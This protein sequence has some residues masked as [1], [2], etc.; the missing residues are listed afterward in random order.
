MDRELPSSDRRPLA[1]AVRQFGR[2]SG[3][4][5]G[6]IVAGALLVG[7]DDGGETPSTRFTE[8]PEVSLGQAIEGELSS[9]SDVNLKDGSRQGS[10]WVCANKDADSS[11]VLYQLDAPFA[12]DVTV[13]DDAGGWLGDAHSSSD[14]QVQLLLAPTDSCSLVVVSGRDMSAFGPWSL[15]PGK[16]PAEAEPAGEGEDTA[17]LKDGQV[18]AGHLGQENTTYSFRLQEAS[19]VEL[20]LSGARGAALTLTGDN[21]SEKAARCADDQQTLETFLEP[22]NYEANLKPG[23]LAKEQVN[24][25]CEDSL[26]SVGD[27]FRLG[28]GVSDLS[29]GQRNSGPLRNGD[30]ISGTLTEDAPSNEYTL[31]ITEPTQVKLNLRSSDFDT[32][33]NVR[34]EQTDISIDDSGNSTDSMLD[35]VLMPGEYRIEATSYEDSGTYDIELA[36]APFDGEVQNS[37]EL[38]PGQGLLGIAGGGEGNVYTLS[39]DQPSEV[40]IKLSSTAFDT[41]LYLEGNGIS[42]NDDDGGGNTNSQ[43]TSMLEPGEYR[44]TVDSYDGMASGMFRMET[45]VTPFNGEQQDSGELTADEVVRGKLSSSGSNHYEFTLGEPTEVTLDMRS[46]EFDALLGMTGPDIELRD[47]DSGGRTDA[48]IHAVLAAGTYEVEASSYGGSGAFTL[49]LNTQPFDGEI[50]SNGE[51]RPGE[52]VYGQLLPGGSLTYQLVVEET[53]DISIETQSDSVD[54]LLQLE[55]ENISLQDDDSG[56]TEL[57]SM[58]ETQLEPGT[59][60]VVV[61]GYEGVSGVVRVDVK[62]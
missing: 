44:V 43:L 21:V 11:G 28:L 47:D 61:T 48:R 32:I 12:A 41:M 52:T 8:A 54:T 39:L 49:Q 42:L 15:K 59:Y 22:G 7:C 23:Q 45:M 30:R 57:G 50:R 58:I 25:E 33:L 9:A 1:Q 5:A 16:Q 31:E 19:R 24:T 26:V 10:Y 14:Q 18:I 27:G 17:T 3:A 51:V 40:T 29:R 46:N 55:G 37:G 13:F 6:V 2:A 20:T 38:T 62:G 36:T 35:T 56:S 34:G 4:A 53:S 60:E